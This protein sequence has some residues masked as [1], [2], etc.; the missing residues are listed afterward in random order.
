[1]KQSIIQSTLLIALASAATAQVGMEG[2]ETGNPDGWEMWWSNYTSVPT[3]GGNPGAY[4]QLDN[5]TSGPSNC[6]FVPIFPDANATGFLHTGNWRAAGV[7]A[8]TI[9]LDVQ[10]GLFL[11]DL[12]LELISDPNTPNDPVDD[13]IISVVLSAAGP[14]GPGWNTY[15][16]DVPSGQMTAPTG[17]EVDPNSPCDNG[18]PSDGW[19]QIIVDVDRIQI[20]YDGFPPAF[21]NFTNWIIGADNITVTSSGPPPVGTNYCTANANSTGVAAEMSAVGSDVAAANLVTMTCSSMPS[22]AFGFMITSMAQ[23]FIMNPGG[24]SG[25]LCLGGTIGRYVGPGQIQNSGSMGEVSLVLDLNQQPTPTGFVAVQAGETWN[26]STW[27]RD[28]GPA[29]PTSNFSDGYSILF[30]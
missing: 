30:L 23:G 22:N 12:V 19:N 2:F 14:A 13:C 20:T 8:V 16:F 17:W 10:E 5:V 15:T 26:F 3:T 6:H 11:G 9:D 24:S 1:M 25:N 28:S 27:F 7:D 29:G 4:L 21:C 18:V